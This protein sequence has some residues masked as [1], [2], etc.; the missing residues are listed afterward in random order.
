[1]TGHNT[2]V[3]HPRRIPRGLAGFAQSLRDVKKLAE[4]FCLESPPFALARDVRAVDS[5]R[6]LVS[7]P[8][9]DRGMILPG[10]GA[11]WLMGADG[12]AERQKDLFA[13]YCLFK[14]S[15]FV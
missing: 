15:F 8:H 1:M 13:L 4:Q 10:F 12:Y 9:A 11:G 6:K 2:P 5:Q 7:A 3:A 14:K